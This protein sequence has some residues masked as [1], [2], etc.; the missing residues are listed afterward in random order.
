M[1]VIIRF[2]LNQDKNS[3]LR[4]AL[5]PLLEAQGIMWT[6][7]TTST[8]E[9]NVL[10]KN[11]RRALS[12][13]WRALANNATN[14]HLDHFWMYSD[15]LDAA[16]I[17]RMEKAAEK[18]LDKSVKQAVRKKMTLKKMAKKKARR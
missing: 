13:F 16:K 7:G 2:S 5:K 15:N 8:Y 9:G 4:N 3:V 6:G 17:A 18:E 1:R 10:E 11:V 12:R 14:A